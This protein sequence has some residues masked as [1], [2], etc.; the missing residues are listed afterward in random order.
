[1]QR[2]TAA[3][4]LLAGLL[5]VAACGSTAGKSEPK[6]TATTEATE[7]FTEEPS[8]TLAAPTDTAVPPQPTDT[9]VPPAVPTDTPVVQTEN[10]DRQSY[11]DVC[12]PPYPPDLNCDDIAYR[13]FRVLPPDPHG[14]DGNNNNGVGC[15]SG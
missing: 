5:L 4:F 15:E 2:W 8:P 9:P 13:G 14:F 7:V 12:I 10:C 1:M 6:G 11:P 3:L